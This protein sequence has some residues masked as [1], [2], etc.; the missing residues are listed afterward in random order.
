[1]SEL[2]SRH[3]LA[4][5]FRPISVAHICIQPSDLRYGFIPTLIPERPA[6]VLGITCWELDC[7]P[8]QFGHRH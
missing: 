2:I 8:I 1:M 7:A 3:F 6:S 5:P 4:E